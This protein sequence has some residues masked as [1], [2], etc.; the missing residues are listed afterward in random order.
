MT[1]GSKPPR[2]RIQTR[3]AARLAGVSRS[4]VLRAIHAEDPDAFPP[5]LPASRLGGGRNAR[6]EIW[7]DDLE[8]WVEAMEDAYPA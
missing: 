8:A 2:R 3:E 5:P 1:R 6:Y 7:E 4:T